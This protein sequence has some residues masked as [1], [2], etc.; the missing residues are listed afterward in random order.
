MVII[1]YKTMKHIKLFEGYQSESEVQEICKK[2]S[3]KNWSINSDG[4]VDVNG[5]VNLNNQGLTEIPLKFGKVTGDFYC[6]D[7]NLTTLKGAPHR[8]GGRFDCDDNRLTSLEFCPSLVGGYFYCRH[9][10]IRE[11]T[12]LKYI[13]GDFYCTGNPIEKIWDI[14]SPNYKWDED[15]MEFFEDCSI[16][17]DDGQSVAIDRLNFFLEEIGLEPVEK[18]DG[19]NNI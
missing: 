14:I 19:Y 12:G 17:H 7:N 10:N 18:V 1:I 9:N 13:G 2:Y 3:I 11:F 4:L 16:I 8:V 6:N 5:N 15:L